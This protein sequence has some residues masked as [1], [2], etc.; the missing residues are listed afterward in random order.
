MDEN[1]VCLTVDKLLTNHTI[2][3]GFKSTV[4]SGHGHAACGRNFGATGSADS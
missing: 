2:E 3:L 4:K 1:L